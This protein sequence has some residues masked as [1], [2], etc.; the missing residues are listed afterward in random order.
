M[1]YMEFCKECGALLFPKKSINDGKLVFQ[2]RTCGSKIGNAD[3]ILHIDLQE[4][5][6]KTWFVKGKKNKN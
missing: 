6:R 3:L 5:E 2:C 4:E 1:K